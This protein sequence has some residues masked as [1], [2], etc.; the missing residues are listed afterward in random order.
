MPLY[1]DLRSTRAAVTASW[2]SVLCSLFH[3]LLS[4]ALFHTK[5]KQY[6]EIRSAFTTTA[7][8]GGFKAALQGRA[9]APTT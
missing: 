1:E 7:L 3:V 9:G 8:L 5:M 2:A 6:F 4:L